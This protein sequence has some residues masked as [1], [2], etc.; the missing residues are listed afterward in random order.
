MHRRKSLYNFWIYLKNGCKLCYPST[1]VLLCY[2]T[3]Y[4]LPQYFGLILPSC[5]CG[6]YKKIENLYITDNFEINNTSALIIEAHPKCNIVVH[7][8]IAWEGGGTWKLT[9]LIISS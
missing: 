7:S 9:N 8:N 2:K 1:H 5:V 4:Y 6:T 3:I